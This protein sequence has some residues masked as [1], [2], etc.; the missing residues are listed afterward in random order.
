MLMN[1]D[2]LKR[3][4]FNNDKE[5]L[6]KILSEIG[7]KIEDAAEKHFKSITIYKYPRDLEKMII[8]NLKDAGY[9]ATLVFDYAFS[10]CIYIS[11]ED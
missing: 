3:K 6:E 4:Y 11:W 7:N 1:K 9:S 5:N 10:R 8:K 2:D